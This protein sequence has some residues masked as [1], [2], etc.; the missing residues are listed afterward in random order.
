MCLTEFMAAV[1]AEI[2][3]SSRWLKY[4]ISCNR[5]WDS[6]FTNFS[7]PSWEM[8]ILNSVWVCEPLLWLFIIANGALGPYRVQIFPS[9]L[10]L[11]LLSV[12]TGAREKEKTLNPGN[13][14]L[15]LNIMR[16]NKNKTKTKTNQKKKRNQNRFEEQLVKGIKTTNPSGKKTLEGGNLPQVQ[17]DD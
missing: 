2:K 15:N 13:L 3:C 7:F 8:Q 12:N 1:S 9:E 10:G 6:E 11:Q 4:C 5:V 17:E 14:T 16:K